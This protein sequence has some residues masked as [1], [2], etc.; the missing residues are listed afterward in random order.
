MK[1]RQIGYWILLVAA[2]L[3]L[4]CPELAANEESK[5][6]IGPRNALLADGAN[7]LLAGDGVEGVRLT[8]RGLEMAQGE[9]ERKMGHSNLCAGYILIDKPRTALPHC[10]WVLE[11]YPNHWRTYN[12][13]ALV[14]LKLERFEES[15][16]DI[17][18]GQE[19][20]PSSRNLKIA[21]GM[22]LDETD[23]VRANVEIDE[24]RS[25]MEDASDDPPNN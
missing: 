14:Y 6:V 3:L 4:A 1:I 22:L 16:A 12:N 25:A 20:S 10:N 7:A 24:R 8:L 11:R 2:F 13:R 23:P 18:R 17:A 15:E 9:V 5:V 19:L 21:K